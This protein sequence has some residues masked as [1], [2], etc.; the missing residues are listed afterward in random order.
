MEQQLLNI[1]SP[2]HTLR[3]SASDFIE[4]QCEADPLSIFHQLKSIILSAESNSTS[5]ELASMI[6]HRNLLNKQGRFEKLPAAELTS[7]VISL[8]QLV[9]TNANLSHAFIKRSSEICVEIAVKGDCIKELIQRLVALWGMAGQSNKIKSF[10]LY[11][12]ELVCEFGGETSEPGLLAIIEQGLNDTDTELQVSAAMALTMLLNTTKDAK[13]LQTYSGVV[14]KLIQL[15]VEM[16]KNND[17]SKGLKMVQAFDDMASFQPKFLLPFTESLVFLFTEMISSESV[18]HSVKVAALN[19]FLT[20]SEKNPMALKKSPTFSDK[21]LVTLFRAFMDCV[22]EELTDDTKEAV[23]QQDMEGVVSSLLPSLSEALGAK[24]L[25][26]KYGP[27]IV[28]GLNSSSWKAQYT[29]MLFVGLLCEG[30]KQH[31]KNDLPGL[32]SLILPYL[33]TSSTKVLHG[34]LAAVGLLCSEYKP[35]IQ[36]NYYKTILPELI[37]LMDANGAFEPKISG[38]AASCLINFARELITQDDEEE[39]TDYSFIFEGY[40][41]MIAERMAGLF[42]KGVATNDS[43]LLEETLGLV[44]VLSHLLKTAFVPYY[45]TFMDGI[46]QLISNLN[47]NQLTTQQSSLKCLLIDTAAFLITACA[48]D[49]STVQTDLN[50]IVAYL[51]ATVPT[52]NE[53]DPMLKSVLSFY[54]VVCQKLKK[55]F[56]PLLENVMQLSLSCARKAVKIHFEEAET[57]QDKGDNFKSM[58]FDMKIFGGKKVLSINHAVLELKINA[59]ECLSVL[60]KYFCDGM[61]P[62]HREAIFELIKSHLESLQSAM[63]KKLCLKMLHCLV[64]ASS[65]KEFNLIMDE[66]CSHLVTDITRQIPK[67]DEED[68]LYSMNKLYK[69]FTESTKTKVRGVDVTLTGPTQALKYAEL[70]K[71]VTDKASEVRAEIVKGYTGFNLDDPEIKEE[72]EDSCETVAEFDRVAMQLSGELM[73]YSNPEVHNYIISNVAPYYFGLMTSPGSKSQYLYSLCYL[74]DMMEYT[75]EDF[76]N[77]HKANAKQLALA[78]LTSGD[79]TLDTT[80]TA[81]YLLGS[82]YFRE[83]TCDDKSMAMTCVQKLNEI[84]DRQEAYSDDENSMYT[85]NALAALV[86]IF[87]IHWHVVFENDAQ[88]TQNLHYV[89]GKLPLEHDREESVVVNRYLALGFASK[90]GFLAGSDD[91]LQASRNYTERLRQMTSREENADLVD[92]HFSSTS[93]SVTN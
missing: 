19:F 7:L 76:F 8:L 80:Q 35:E 61:N 43:A 52:L 20:F 63:V 22:T 36:K 34:C 32:L 33:K 46:K 64:K 16:I 9:S 24:F 77:Q 6:M 83:K 69:I 40:I 25:F 66:L 65:E 67:E 70:C 38:R 47:S 21:T 89:L 31:F 26:A 50:E 79:H 4:S 37:R 85:D 27:M 2:D 68:L 5:V 12:V 73:K 88:V 78:T 91:R 17:E 48:D 87:M 60:C 59:F 55:D 62:Q 86:K 51:Q 57:Y 18:P 30:T 39:E 45:R 84:V 29:A 72:M 3:A 23:S 53:E 74:A 54:T 11:S 58:Q 42:S 75:S 92:E 14:E 41:P 28:E 1:L 15:M 13:T 10:V 81:V 44:S 90:N 71:K 82:I 93:K 56:Q 49:I